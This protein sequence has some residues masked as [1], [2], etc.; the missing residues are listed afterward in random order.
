MLVGKVECDAAVM[1]GAS[2]K[3]GAAGAVSGVCNP[4]KL[5]ARILAEQNIEQ[6]LGLQAPL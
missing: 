1:D 3:F 5:A 6:P 2:L 4:I